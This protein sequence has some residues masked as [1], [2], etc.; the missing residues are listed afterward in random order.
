M[1]CVLPGAFGPKRAGGV[2]TKTTVFRRGKTPD[3]AKTGGKT[4]ARQRDPS[5][6]R[7]ALQTPPA[8]RCG[9]SFSSYGARRGAVPPPWYDRRSFSRPPYHHCDTRPAPLPAAG[10]VGRRRR[11][12]QH[13]RTRSRTRTCGPSDRNSEPNTEEN[14]RKTRHRN[15]RGGLQES[16]ESIVPSTRK[17]SLKLFQVRE[18]I[19]QPRGPPI[20][21]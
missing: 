3:A 20:V 15:S 8:E 16:P 11:S 9:C 5:G 18:R 19:K 1:V 17:K 10:L 2:T 13:H 6:F 21:R 4:P 12:T 7:R 14:R